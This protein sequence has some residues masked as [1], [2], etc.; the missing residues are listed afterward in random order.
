M[1]YTLFD[2]AR[3]LRLYEHEVCHIYFG[4]KSGLRDEEVEATIQEAED[5]I[6]GYHNW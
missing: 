2:L 3:L 6:K 4:A 1:D 5:I